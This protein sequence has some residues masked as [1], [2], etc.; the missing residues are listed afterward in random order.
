MD[1]GIAVTGTDEE[2]STE[3]VQ[4]FVDVES[5]IEYLREVGDV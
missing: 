2:W 1:I 3:D 4:W 5:A